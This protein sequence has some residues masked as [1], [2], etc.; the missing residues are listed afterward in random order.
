[1]YFGWPSKPNSVKDDDNEI[2]FNDGLKIACLTAT[3]KRHLKPIVR[4]L[5]NQYTD[6]KNE[7][8]KHRFAWRK[9]ANMYFL[10]IEYIRIG[11][12]RVMKKGGVQIV[13]FLERKISVI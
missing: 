6:V 1:M 7:T 4:F 2:F 13:D 10:D 8:W 9:I 12:K 5:E 3:C 11:W